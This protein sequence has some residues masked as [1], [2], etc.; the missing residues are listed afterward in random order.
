MS[1]SNTEISGRKVFF[2]HPSAFVENTII[3]PLVQQE[4]EIYMVKDETKIPKILKKYPDSVVFACID[5]VLT[6]K[7][8]EEWVIQH[9]ATPADNEMELGVLSNTNNDDIRKLYVETLKVP[10]GFIPVKPDKDKAIKALIEV[11]N[12]VKAKGRRK[13]VRT[14]TRG[15]A[16]T[17]IN[18]PVGDRYV[19]G[20]IRDISVVGL[21]CTFSEELNLEKNAIFHDIQIKLQSMLLKVEG[22]VFG[23]R[24]EGLE[25]IYIFIFSPKTDSTTRS[26]IRVFIQKRNQSMMDAEIV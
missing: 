20:E 6:P 25:T 3:E 23:S 1:D 16:M 22:V 5:E 17:T 21:S 14:N 2:L 19:T 8:W 24:T 7:Q 10:C 12:A 4:F 9:R 15:E 18:L 13:Y 26:K 11:L